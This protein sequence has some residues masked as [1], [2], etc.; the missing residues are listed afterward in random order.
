MSAIIRKSARLAVKSKMFDEKQSSSLNL[1]SSRQSHPINHIDHESDNKL[2]LRKGSSAKTPVKYSKDK[3]S[4]S[5]SDISAS[6][7]SQNS[8]ELVGEKCKSPKKHK[9]VPESWSNNGPSTPPKLR[10]LNNETYSSNE[11]EN[12]IVS[13][14][15]PSAM[16]KKLSINSP[17]KKC[18]GMGRSN[19][20]KSLFS[21]HIYQ[22]AKMALHS[23]TPQS[24]P[25]RQ[26][27]FEELETFIRNN[28]QEKRSA[29]LY[30]SGPPGTGKTASLS[31]ILEKE[32]ILENFKKVYVNCTSIKSSG[33]VFSRIIK[34]LELKETARNERE[35]LN[36]I[37]NI[38]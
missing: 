37:E 13:P 12:I 26:T 38:S 31:L 2:C 23:T 32:E 36:I 1:R 34:E 15:T 25:G 24:M 3:D 33:A 21:G 16:L 4:D 29:S 22:N 18:E 11:E 8:I 10:K 30:I 5:E 9:S 35:S 19:S 14:K 28:F 27:E 20:R 6:T 7:S 17:S